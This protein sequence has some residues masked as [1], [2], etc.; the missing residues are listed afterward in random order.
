MQTTII[1]KFLSAVD[2]ATFQKLMNH[3]LHLEGYK[4]LSSPGSVV[5][6][7]KTSKGS[8]DSFFEDGDKYVFCELTTQEKLSTGET[9]F[10]KLKK[11]I[12]HCFDTS[13]TSINNADISKV[14]LG[15]TEKLKP[16]EHKELKDRVNKHNPQAQ[17]IIY[18]I[19][20]I[21]FR[22][23]YYP[24]LADKYIA[25]VKTTKG[26]FYTLPDFLKTTE[27]GLQPSLTNP[28]LGRD[29]EI[30]QAKSNLLT[31]D[32]LIITGSQGVGKSK[33]A[34]HLAEIFENEFSFEPRVI[35]SSPVPLWEDLNNFILPN[36]KYFIFFDDANK[37][38]PNLDYL[39]QFISTR[40]SG[41]IKIVITV[42]D[43]AKPDLN[44]FLSNVLHNEIIINHLEDKQIEEIVNKSLPTGSSLDP[45][46]MGKIISLSKGNSRLALMATSAI[47]KNNNTEVLADV[48]SLYDQYFQKVKND[49]SFLDDKR[50][51]K[52]L[53]IISFFGVLDRNNEEV[54]TILESQFGINWNQL[55]ET[56]LELEKVELVD[57]F[58]NE[59][60]KI[61]DQ[62]LATYVF[63]KTFIDE[64]TVQIN[65][66]QWIFSF[67]EK[68]E[69]KIS[70]TL[71]DLINTFGFLELRDRITSLILEVQ[72]KLE[73]DVKTLYKFLDIFWFYREV[74]SLLFVKKWI[75]SL[76]KEETELSEIEYIYESNDFVWAPDY[77]KLLLNFW[78]HNTH[79]TREAIDL[80]LKLMFRQP[81][82]IPEIL[83]H[84]T[85]HLQFHRFDY[86]V[87]FPRQ[88][89]FIETLSNT[90]F[91]DREKE[92]SNQIF[93]SVAPSYLGW[94]YHQ[95]EGKS[96]GQIAIYNFHLLKTPALME[97]RKHI[98]Q[99]LQSLFPT[100][101]TSVLKALHKY[102]WTSREI[103][104]SIYADEQQ[105]ITDFIK[106]NLKPENYS[107]CKFVYEYEDTL[108]EHSVTLLTD[109]ISFLNSDSMRIAKIFNGKFN[110]ENLKYDEREKKQKE[111]IEKFVAGKDITFIHS[112]LDQLDSIYKD[113]LVNNDGY[114]I[115]SSLPILFLSLAE[116]N[117]NLY[118]K[119]L[120]L[121][122][123]GKYSF[124]LNQGYF[125][126]RPI[127]NK[128]VKPK[129]I[130]SHLNRYEYRQKQFWK[131]LFFEALE[132]S[133]IDEFLLLEFIGFISSVNDR[134]YI[135]DLENKILYDKQFNVSKSLLQPSVSDHENIVTY[136]TEILLSK[137]NSMDIFFDRH[138]CETCS[139][140]FGKKINLLKQVYFNHKKRD[141]HYDYSG[142]E[143]E[144][145]SSLDNYFLAEYLNEV[146]KD[147]NF[148][149]FK[150]DNLN[151][152]FVWDLQD[153][154]KIIDE[155][156]EIIISKAPI[157]SSFEHQANVLFKGL[158]LSPEQQGKVYSYISKFIGKHSSSK[159]HIH[160]ILN[161]VTFS[162]NNQILRFLREFLL[163]NKD[164][165]FMKHL[166]LERNG[167]FSGSRV[168]RIESHIKFTKAVIE[169]IQSL[170]N[171]LDYAEH[172]K[173]FEQEIEW[174]KQDK[175]Q[176]MK[177][178]FTGWMD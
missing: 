138:T 122:M 24:G 167:A 162:F 11:D 17:L 66:S 120:E 172:I 18:S 145:V 10:K 80:A 23:V 126:Y 112:T 119:S 116:N 65:Y 163:L 103:D 153:Y 49:L 67:V 42:R 48:F 159:Q 58:Q 121:L 33:F 133:D 44:K 134:F 69:K 99:R 171:P 85:E 135:S 20:E 26:T 143:M 136:I 5:G 152:T 92:I 29:E 31:C 164:I 76:D 140:Y 50:N 105:L 123:L 68:H 117:T 108:K 37:A 81:S 30:K 63:Y 25:G 79:Y 45:F 97:L 72:T 150:F 94:D 96:G 9:F 71:V 88:H 95:P 70:K 59:V 156:L 77:L 78:G 115:E 39:L 74:D 61:S 113:A 54:K 125:I 51:L 75:E 106:G 157:W 142:K 38:L 175:Q 147:V 15:F 27:K 2:Q 73:G 1:E 35:A 84:L 22:L 55:W 139:K 3:L 127:K 56:L 131:L 148:L 8:P 137:A 161:V 53:G 178:D 158:K 104:S 90:D 169:M 168:P 40:D 47:V 43:Y 93:L 114:W 109:W 111:E 129:E 28:F 130:Y 52:V 165:E 100:N 146:T 87:G 170:P 46:A 64:S 174:A 101:E 32:I 6:K 4:F 7:N 91:T 110:E 34:V 160:I 102:V 89:V 62:V 118:Y 149:H 154:E 83:K 19:Q 155:A 132:E 16:K 21:P 12:D 173:Y 36:K 144:A 60:V 57:V 41:T 82:R 176:E 124:E 13:V 177:R 14:I 151:L 141:N 86:R 166:W 128:L 107:H 98:L